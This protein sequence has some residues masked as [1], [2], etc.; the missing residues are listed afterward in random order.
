MSNPNLNPEAKTYPSSPKN[1][2]L[3][4]EEEG[5]KTGSPEKQF[6]YLAPSMS[7]TEESTPSTQRSIPPPTIQP[8]NPTY[9]ITT[10]TENPSPTRRVHSIRRYIF[11]NTFKRGIE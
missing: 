1:P 6:V 9:I 2:F 11:C 8:V 10:T 7:P 3:E 5:Y 4:E